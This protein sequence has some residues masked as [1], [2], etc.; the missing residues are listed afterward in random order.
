MRHLLHQRAA[1]PRP[2]ATGAGTC[3]G[4]SSRP[5]RTPPPAPT[6]P[7]CR[8]ATPAR[9]CG[10][11]DKLYE[12]RPLRR[13]QPAPAHR[14]AAARRAAS[15]IPAQFA[16]V[17]TAIVTTA[18]PR[19][20]LNWLRKGAGAAVLAEVAAGRLALTHEALDAHP[21]PQRRRLPAPR[22]G[23]QRRPTRPRRGRGPHRTLGHRPDRNPPHAQDRRLA[24]AYTTWRVLRRLRR[25][26]A[27][28]PRPR[29]YTRRARRVSTLLLLHGQ[30]LSPDHRDHHRPGFT[31]RDQQVFLRFDRDVTSEPL[32]TLLTSLLRDGRRYL[33]IG[34]PATTHWLFPGLHARQ[35]AHRR[36]ARRAPARHSGSGPTQP[37][38]RPHL[39]RRPAARRGPRRPA[40]HC[41]DH[42]RPLGARRRR[43]LEPL[44]RP[45]RQA[46][47]HQP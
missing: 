24:K 11:E 16:G 35:P 45:T 5:A 22:P 13:L 36:P 46:R 41:P 39:P 1:P 42:R 31:R 15:T 18:T 25:G 38:R 9:D 30:P 19:S 21:R 43:R 34:T 17:Y 28:R 37:P 44:R 7:A 26:A 40:R 14:R 2:T 6:A 33:G 4:W 32:A 12:T 47:D 10:I 27:Q 3:A 23:R 29:T 20:A 8:P